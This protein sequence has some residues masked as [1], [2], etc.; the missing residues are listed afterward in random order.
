VKTIADLQDVL[1]RLCALKPL[2][3]T[4]YGAKGIAL[5]GSVVRGEQGPISD[6]D[7]LVEFEEGADLFDLIGLQLYLEQALGCRVDVVSRIALRAEL[8]EAVLR[9]A[10]PV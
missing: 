3:A 9:E 2:I 10:V 1:G 4:R 7:V 5:F 6:V 8:R